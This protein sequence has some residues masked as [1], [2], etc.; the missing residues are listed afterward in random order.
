RTVESL[1]FGTFQIIVN[2]EDRIL[3]MHNSPGY[4]LA[5]T[6]WKHNARI[7]STVGNQLWTQ[8]MAFPLKEMGVTGSPEG[9]WRILVCRNYGIAPVY[10][11]PMTDAGGFMDPNSYSVFHLSKGCLATQQLYSGEARLP[12][13][14]RVA[15]T[16][17]KPAT[18]E[19]SFALSDGKELSLSRRLDIAPGDVAEEDFTQECAEATKCSISMKANGWNRKFTC[20][21]PQLPIWRNTESYQ[22][23]FCSMEAG[24]ADIVDYAAA[25]DTIV[26]RKT[27]VEIPAVQGP[28]A[29]RK[30]QDFTGMTVLFP[31]TRLTSPGAVSFWMRVAEPLPKDKPYRRFFGTDFKPNGYIFFQEQKDGG[32]LIGAQYFGPS[33][34]APKIML[35]GRRPQPG[36]W[37]HIAIN[38]LPE[39]IEVYMNGIRRGILQHKFPID[40]SKVGGPELCNGAFADF[41][42]YSRPLSVGEITMMAQ[43][44]KPVTGN[45]CWYQSLNKA[46]VDLVLGCKAVPERKLQLQVRDANDKMLENFTLDFSKGYINEDNGR[47]MATL[48]VALPLSRKLADGK[49]AFFLSKVN[50]DAPLLERTFQVKGYA[51]LNN[52]IGKADR[53]ITGFTPLQRNGNRLSAVLKEMTLGRNGLPEAISANGGEVLAR[54]VEVIAEANGRKLAWKCQAPKFTSESET[55][56]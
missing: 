45:V 27:D 54:P 21:P 30:V 20:V 34:K 6:D 3:A 37:M 51:W 8:E 52:Q 15:N 53:L 33:N 7:K 28:V 31:N 19:L 44:D 24:K 5:S 43:G 40:F 11:A 1:K 22:T 49:Y 35:L 18:T 26:K 23:L 25:S 48:R 10:Q 42:I 41:S 50:S 16:G 14:F 55:S 17:D 47:E 2:S 13:L 39:T 56:I 32:L 38:F 4:G 36:Q 9:D 46:V 12:L 29:T